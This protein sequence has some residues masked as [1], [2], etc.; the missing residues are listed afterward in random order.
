MPG[1][2]AM[3][4]SMKASLVG[5]ALLVISGVGHAATYVYRVTALPRGTST[6]FAINNSGHV[7]GAGYPP[8]ECL[9]EASVWTGTRPS[10]F[11][12][13]FLPSDLQ[14]PDANCG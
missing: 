2:N 7:T 6:A 3:F 5:L 8:G 13:P 11:I 14:F 10:T 9:G 1:E 4:N 12:G